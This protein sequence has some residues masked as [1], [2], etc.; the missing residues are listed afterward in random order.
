LPPEC[1]RETGRSCKLK[2]YWSRCVLGERKGGKKKQED[3]LEGV[4]PHRPSSSPVREQ[5]V[6]CYEVKRW[7]KGSREGKRTGKG[8]ELLYQDARAR[9]KYHLKGEAADVEE[10]KN[11]KRIGRRAY[12]GD[13]GKGLLGRKV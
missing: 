9:P 11:S 8:V 12:R 4:L 5:Q 6:E 10:G 1:H 7:S 2:L 3:G 13:K